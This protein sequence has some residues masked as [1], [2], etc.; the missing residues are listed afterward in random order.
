[1]NLAQALDF[2]ASNCP[3]VFAPIATEIE[4]LNTENTQLT[5]RVVLAE[6][7]INDMIMAQLN[8]GM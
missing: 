6:S 3:S 8:G 2:L 7:A 4:R 5:E 1:M